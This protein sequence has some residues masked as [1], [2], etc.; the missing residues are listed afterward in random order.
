M[1]EPS[2]PA[3]VERLA[4]GLD[5]QGGGGAQ[6]VLGVVGRLLGDEGPGG[7][8]PGVDA[9]ALDDPLVA[10]VEQGAD[11]VVGDDPLGEGGA[12][13]GDGGAGHDACSQA[14]GWP[15][16]TRS[17]GWARAPS[18]RPANGDRTSVP[19]D[20]AEQGAHLDGRPG[21]RDRGS[22]AGSKIPGPGL[23]TT[24]SE[25]YRCSPWWPRA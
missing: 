2:S 6:P 12:P 4:S 16:W 21:C 15:V 19:D 9:A 11:V 17:P 25:T 5:G 18:R 1:S 20:R 8:P 10:G 7:G 24:R 3:A 13:A 14:I 22:S 23:I